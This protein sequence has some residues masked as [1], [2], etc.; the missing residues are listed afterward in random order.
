MARVDRS[1]LR[2]PGVSTRVSRGTGI[3]QVELGRGAADEIA[4]PACRKVAPQRGPPGSLVTSDEDPGIR[5]QRTCCFVYSRQLS[6]PR[7]MPQKRIL[8]PYVPNPMRSHL[9]GSSVARI[10]R[11]LPRGRAQVGDCHLKFHE[12]RDTFQS[13]SIQY[14]LP[15]CVRIV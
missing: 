5:R 4:E 11:D 6:H 7:S 8:L 14:C 10:T 12:D 3:A 9:K 1:D 2:L 15:D 13:V